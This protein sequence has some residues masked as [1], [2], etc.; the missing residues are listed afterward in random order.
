MKATQL[1][2]FCPSTV[3]DRFI[4]NGKTYFHYSR[5][6]KNGKYNSEL[7]NYVP[8]LQNHSF[9]KMIHGNYS[10]Y[11]DKSR[12]N[13]FHLTQGINFHK[14]VKT[15]TSQ[16][17]SYAQFSTASLFNIILLVQDTN[18][19]KSISLYEDIIGLPIKRK[20]ESLAEFYINSNNSKSIRDTSI[21]S[22]DLDPVLVVRATSSVS[23]CC[24]GYSPI[25]TFSTSDMSDKIMKSLEIGCTLDGA[26]QYAAHGQVATLR[27][28][29]GHMISFYEPAMPV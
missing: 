20:T 25:L 14:V 13:Y 23:L 5:N 18:F 3:K 27:S 22:D 10:T 9:F 24:T 1:T 12:A 19:D 21:S 4:S 8:I 11:R 6:S 7:K 2:C 17:Q 15:R 29:D 16:R 28:P 26:I